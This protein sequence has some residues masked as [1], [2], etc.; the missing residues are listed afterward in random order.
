MTPTQ[1]SMTIL[2]R[3]QFCDGLVCYTIKAGSYNKEEHVRIRDGKANGCTC[4]NKGK[5]FNE[6]PHQEALVRLEAAYQSH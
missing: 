6:C 1:E 3:E 5:R 2:H 4:K